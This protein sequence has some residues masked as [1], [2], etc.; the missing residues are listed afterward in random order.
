MPY[1]TNT[2]SRRIQWG[3][4]DPAGIVFY[5]QYF[6][7]F[8]DVVEMWFDQLLPGGYAG[9]IGQSHVGLPTVRLEA[10]FKAISRMGD[11]VTLS[12][13]VERLG[14]KSITFR[15]ACTGRDGDLRMSVLQT[16]VTTSLETH[17]SIAVP[18]LLRAALG[19][20]AA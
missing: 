9:L 14:T 18:E 10:E 3:E 15:L 19:A 16:I 20:P 17:E 5:P 4:C 13:E 8:N 2:T 1:L 6:V 11:D 12:I 7:L